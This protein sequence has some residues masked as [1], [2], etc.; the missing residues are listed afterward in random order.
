MPN[1]YH[2]HFESKAIYVPNNLPH[3]DIKMNE[4]GGKVETSL[5]ISHNQKYQNHKGSDTIP[6]VYLCTW[7]HLYLK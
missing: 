1:I 5:C 4:I 7:L 6:G 3:R 2:Y